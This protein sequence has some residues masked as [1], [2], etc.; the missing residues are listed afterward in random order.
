MSLLEQMQVADSWAEALGKAGY[1]LVPDY[2]YLS[3]LAERKPELDRSFLD[4]PG[5]VERLTN[6]LNRYWELNRG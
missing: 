1:E 2:S 5:Y 3:A 6:A 4:Q